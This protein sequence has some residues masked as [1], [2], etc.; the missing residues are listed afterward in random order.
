MLLQNLINATT[1][2]IRSL[3]LG[4]FCWG[5]L[6]LLKQQNV[7]DQPFLICLDLIFGQTC[8]LVGQNLDQN[9]LVGKILALPKIW[10][11]PTL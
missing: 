8:W 1:H 3:L 2:L 10:D 5:L 6:L 7:F 9:M 11:S 4:P